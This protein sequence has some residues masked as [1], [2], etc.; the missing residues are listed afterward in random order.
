MVKK[1]WVNKISFTWKVLVPMLIVVLSFFILIAT[2]TYSNIKKIHLQ[3]LERE[4]SLEIDSIEKQFS[5]ELS[6]KG[7]VAQCIAEKTVVD[8]FLQHSNRR[9]NAKSFDLYKSVQQLLDDA[10]S[11]NG[12]IDLAWVA[13]VDGEIILG[14]SSVPSEDIYKLKKRPWFTLAVK[15]EDVFYTKP[16][17]DEYM[18]RRTISIIYPI[19]SNNKRTGYV[20]IDVALNNL[21][22]MSN[23]GGITGQN[24]VL[25][26]SNSE[27]LLDDHRMWPLF[28]D[29]NIPLNVPSPVSN[30]KGAY[31]V[32]LREVTNS[33]WKM[34]V[35]VLEEKVL[36]P[37]KGFQKKI[38]FFWLIA[39]LILFFVIKAVLKY[40]MRDFN[41]VVDQLKQ[42]ENG[43]Y[44]KKIK[45]QRKDEVGRIADAAEHMGK[46]IHKQMEILNFQANFDMLTK[47]PNRSSIEQKIENGIHQSQ[48][49]NAEMTVAFIDV[50]NFKEVNDTYGHAY[51]DELLIQIGQRVQARLGENSYFG[52]FGGDEF[53]LLIKANPKAIQQNLKEILQIFEEP[54][55]LHG[56][57]V[58]AS[59]SIGVADYPTDSLSR[60][61][62]LAK[63]DTA[64]YEAKKQGRNRIEFFQDEMKDCFEKKMRL[65][66]GLHTALENNEFELFYQPQLNVSLGYMASAE[67]LIRW[68][69]PEWGM[70]SPAEFIPLAESSGRISSIGAW[71]I[72][73]GFKMAKELKQHYP[74]LQRIGLNVSSVQLREQNF[75]EQV[76]VALAEYN[77][78]PSLIEFE[79]TES[80][81]IDRLEETIEKLSELKKLG[82]A[83]A[84]D[85]FGTGY[86]SLNYLRRLPIDRVKL[87]RS[88]IQEMDED[89]KLA[90]MVHHII[91]M[92]HGIG[93]EVVAEGVETE[94]QMQ[95]LNA[96]QVD[97]VQG[98]F[99]SRPI[100]QKGLYAFIDAKYGE[101][102]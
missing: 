84:L 86:S 62:L 32:E 16:Y 87:D 15:Q 102:Q 48:L 96:L 101:I 91:E 92:A 30:A 4:L 90:T 52:R 7:K 79:I 54:F 97:K 98:Y 58:Y 95:M 71:V 40:S 24:I 59:V 49:Q 43:D 67:A 88:F 65:E 76:K 3:Q 72:D 57:D 75:V 5:N 22:P 69:H 44:T 70:V 73:E 36:A 60:G 33:D 68:N 64:L 26:S 39:M 14:N 8:K 28:E 55:D 85:D 78:E 77:I 34:A 6:Q 29:E 37:L 82:I 18:K 12:H 23:P 41:S 89:P 42:I 46:Q 31:Y 93:L 74:K 61:G 99:Y 50:D 35:Y 19:T 2:F 38:I 83:L 11:M 56:Y 21:L 10:K 81:V 80:V 100:D 13:N 47:L 27:I 20:G 17:E 9:G 53:I 66:A 63:A 1:L 94:K 51:G 45:V 25:L